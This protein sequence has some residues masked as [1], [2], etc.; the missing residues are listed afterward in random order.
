MTSAI[1]QLVKTPPAMQ[2]TP[3][4]FLGQEDPLEKEQAT[5]PRILRLP[6][7][8]SWQRIPLNAGDLGLIPGLGKSPG[9]GNGYPLKHS[10]LENSM[11]FTV[12]G[13]TKSQTAEQLSLSLSTW[14][15]EVGLIEKTHMQPRSTG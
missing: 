2:E 13:V 12:H 10:G 7:W 4:R 9:E 14:C 15:L 5:H 1:A 11:D 8:F 3:V 6:L